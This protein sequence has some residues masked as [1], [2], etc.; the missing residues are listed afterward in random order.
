MLR[1]K[2]P[3]NYRN[4]TGV[5]HSRLDGNP[6][7]FESTLERDFI[8][9]LRFDTH[10][11]S[12]YESQTPTIS[13]ICAQGRN[14]KYTPDLF[15]N[16]AD[17]RQVMYEVKPRDVLWRN[18]E[19]L[20]PKFKHAIRYGKERGFTFK[21]VTE[22]EIRTDYLANI[23]FLKQFRRQDPYDP[24]CTVLLEKLDL[25]ESSTPQKLIDLAG[26]SRHARAELLHTLW[27]LVADHLIE[28]EMYEPIT[29]E[30]VIWP[31]MRGNTDGR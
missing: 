27:R 3:L 21:I 4:V 16:Y 10:V 30:S 1:R 7:P 24:R 28:I 17:G 29:M 31:V 2:V 25:L 26:A 14:R 13:Y 18:W 11:V 12:S 19:E 6:T 9:I 20:K 23:R 5:A 15:V 22:V 8:E